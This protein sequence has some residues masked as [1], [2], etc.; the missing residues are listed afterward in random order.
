ML[1]NSFSQS[2]PASAPR[3]AEALADP[4]WSN[5]KILLVEDALD[6]A[7]LM[8]DLLAAQGYRAIHFPGGR[9]ALDWAQAHVTDLAIL[10]LDLPDLSGWEL[11][12]RLR[13]M[14]PWR[15]RPVLICSGQAVSGAARLR[16]HGAAGFI[17]K[18]FTATR[19]LR[20]VETALAD[21]SQP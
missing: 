20:A 21:A 5:R 18:P 4:P 19:F 13:R 9:S 17:A 12:R 14:N 8:M 10:D 15:N 7:H 6:L 3:A 2:G 11:C 1:T 16:A